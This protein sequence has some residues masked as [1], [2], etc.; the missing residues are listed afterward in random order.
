MVIAKALSSVIGSGVEGFEASKQ[1]KYPGYKIP[2]SWIDF[3]VFILILAVVA[4]FGQLMW[5]ELIAK[6]I[7]V[8]KPLPTI[9]HTLGMYVALDIFFGN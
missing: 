8:I 5:N 2:K 1:N 6:Y 3:V 9:F 4:F 7:T